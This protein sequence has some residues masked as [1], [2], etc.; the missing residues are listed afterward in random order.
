M[1]PEESRNKKKSRK[2]PDEDMFNVDG[3]VSQ[4]G[5][6]PMYGT[7]EEC[8]RAGIVGVGKVGSALWKV[9]D[10][11][12]DVIPLDPSEG[13]DPPED[14]FCVDHL[15]I[16]IPYTPF[17]IDHVVSWL[18]KCHPTLTM[19]HTTTPPGTTKI[20]SDKAKKKGLL[21]EVT[22]S[23]V[24]G[25]HPHLAEH[26]CHF[27]KMVGQTSEGSGRMGCI[28]LQ[29][30]GIPCV[31][32]DS[33]DNTEWAKLLCLVRYGMDI[34]F[35][36]AVRKVCDENNLNFG[37]VYSAW[38]EAYNRGYAMSG[39][40]E[41][42]RPILDPNKGGLGEQ[43]VWEGVMLLMENVDDNSAIIPFINHVLTLGKKSP[44]KE[45]APE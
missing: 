26:L 20:V 14:D 10:P 29:Q 38:T 24:V 27:V 40:P 43:G 1:P 39:K 2:A 9:L 11:V 5:P 45:G 15:H 13:Y 22:H 3:P 35:T 34:A 33:S 41:Y 42:I 18:E 30:A 36:T 16:C 4:M 17:F 25:F 6:Y 28:A 19:I 37:Q 7:K 32:F 12:F 23:P 8:L 21:S 31:G 44:V